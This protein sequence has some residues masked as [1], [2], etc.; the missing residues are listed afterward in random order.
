MKPFQ[1]ISSVSKKKLQEA[2]ESGYR[3]VRLRLTDKGRQ[4]ARRAAR[5]IINRTGYQVEVSKDNKEIVI[6]SSNTIN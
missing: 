3:Q 6:R 2:V 5:D 4:H 1:V